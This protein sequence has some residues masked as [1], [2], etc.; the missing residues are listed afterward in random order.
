MK[1]LRFQVNTSVAREQIDAYNWQDNLFVL[2]GNF[3]EVFRKSLWRKSR[4]NA[5]PI[6]DK[7]IVM[8]VI[9]SND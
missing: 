2:I 5:W 7:L 4:K 3:P 1:S 8:I 9:H 6:D